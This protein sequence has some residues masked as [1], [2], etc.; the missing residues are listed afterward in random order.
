MVDAVVAVE[1][2]TRRLWAGA[3]VGY[4]E[5]YSE[6]HEEHTEGMRTTWRTL[7]GLD[8]VMT[9]ANGILFWTSRAICS[10]VSF[11]HTAMTVDD[12]VVMSIFVVAIR[13]CVRHE[14][15]DE[16]GNGDGS[17]SRLYTVAGISMGVRHVGHDS[18]PASSINSMQPRQKQCQHA[19]K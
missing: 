9:L 7:V 18:T 15:I 13:D 5:G 4:S 19:D 1:R 2:I 3:S 17:G 6:G 8:A 10:I 14:V 12:G 16:A 11:A